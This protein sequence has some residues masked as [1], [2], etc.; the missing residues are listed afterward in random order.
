MVPMTE[1]KFRCPDMHFLADALDVERKLFRSPGVYEVQIDH[2][3]GKVRVLTANQDGGVDVR[4]TLAAAGFPAE[5][6]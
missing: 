6:Y 1:L 4:R 5:L 2:V 3:S